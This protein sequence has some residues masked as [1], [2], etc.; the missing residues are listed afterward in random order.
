MTDLYDPSSMRIKKLER[1]LSL[2]ISGEIDMA[3]NSS[4]W[5]IGEVLKE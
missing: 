1:I 5:L 4:R 2:I 3:C